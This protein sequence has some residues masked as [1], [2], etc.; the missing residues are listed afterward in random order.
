[1]IFNFILFFLYLLLVIYKF[2]RSKINIDNK[3]MFLIIVSFIIIAFL[4]IYSLN[5]N[6][7]LVTNMIILFILVIGLLLLDFIIVVFIKYNEL[8]KRYND[9]LDC[10]SSKEEL[11]NKYRIINHENKN[12]LAIIRNIGSYKLAKDYIDQL[13][14]I[15]DKDEEID[16]LLKKIPSNQIRAILYDKFVKMKN[17]NIAYS[18]IVSRNVKSKDLLCI[19]NNIM[20]DVIN[21]IG[22][23][24][25]NA[26]EAD[27]DNN[28][29]SFSM[30]KDDEICITISNRCGNDIDLSSIFKEGYS[31][32]GC[33][34][35]YGLSYVSN[36]LKKNKKINLETDIVD[37]IFSQMIRIHE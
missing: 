25:D 15:H 4:I 24:M 13:L 36:I 22:V 28:Y 30:S 20:F 19:S 16:K 21:I 6:N 27:V 12:H 5:M 37:N 2:F 8:L 34:H 32:K 33:G 9:V 14:D 29:I 17:S 1:M 18:L 7:L 26:I 11:L 31:S 23:L 35:G 3:Y 10:L